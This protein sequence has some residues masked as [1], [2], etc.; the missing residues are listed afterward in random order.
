M[1]LSGLT[2]KNQADLKQILKFLDQQGFGHVSD[3]ELHQKKINSL[4]SKNNTLGITYDERIKEDLRNLN[5][6][7][8]IDNRLKKYF[9]GF[10]VDD[11]IFEF[12]K[13]F[14]LSS[15]DSCSTPWNRPE[16]RDVIAWIKFKERFNLKDEFG[17]SKTIDFY[18]LDKNYLKIYFGSYKEWEFK[19]FYKLI[20]NEDPKNFDDKKVGAWQNLGKIEIKFFMK[21]GANI[22][23]DLTKIKE[24]YNKYLIKNIYHHTI[25]KYNNK[26]NIIKDNRED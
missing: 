20:F 13:T 14:Y 23:G 19:Q 6:Y 1:N 22:K 10:N 3:W 12:I 8:E 5:D 25:I 15:D 16:A 24:Y 18:N 9:S 21:G 4:I 26:L 2:I 11:K 7:E 17:A